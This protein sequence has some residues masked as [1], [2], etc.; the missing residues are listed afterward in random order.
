VGGEACKEA[1]LDAFFCGF[2]AKKAVRIRLAVS[3]MWKRFR[4]SRNNNIPS[5]LIEFAKFHIIRHL[6][7][8]L[9]QVGRMEYRNGKIK[10]DYS[11]IKGHRYSLWWSSCE[12]LSLGRAGRKALKNTIERQ[13]VP[14]YRLFAGRI[15]WSICGIPKP[16]ETPALF[17][18]TERT[19]EMATTGALSGIRDND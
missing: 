15:L 11:Y 6:A 1:D 2:G 13:R 10:K 17:R 9:D 18:A 16:N 4:N 19:S 14:Q 12:N 7:D 8:A 3:D 5:A